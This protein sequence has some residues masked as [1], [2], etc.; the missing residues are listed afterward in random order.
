MDEDFKVGTS[1]AVIT[2]DKPL[3]M[4]GY[5]SRKEKAQGKLDDLYAKTLY[6]RGRHGLGFLVISL[7]L[8]R[9]DNELYDEIAKQIS[10]Q[11]GLRKEQIHVVATHTHSGPEISTVFWN[12]LP[13]SS[14]EEK[15][16]L[17]YRNQLIETV[18]RTAVESVEK[19]EKARLYVGK[20]L[21]E[22]VGSNRVDPS[23]PKDNEAMYLV[24][25]KDD[26]TYKVILVNYACHPTVLGPENK[27]YSGDLAGMTC[28]LIEDKFGVM[29]MY[30]NGAA[31]N[32]STRH[33][34][35]G[36]NYEWLKLLASRLAE[37]I[38]ESI[39]NSRYEP[40]EKNVIVSG[41]YVYRLKT[42][43]I[44]KDI[45]NILE[46]KKQIE[47]KLEQLKKRNPS[48]AEIRDLESRLE[49]I[50]VLLNRIMML[51]KLESIEARISYVKI[52]D[53]AVFIFFPGEVYVELQ[54]IAKKESR[55]PYVFFVGYADGYIGYVP[56]DKWGVEE[57]LMSYEKIVSIIDPGEVEKIVSIIREIVS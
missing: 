3:I 28:Q 17:D 37:P 52:G 39:S 12:T 16:I 10:Q 20:T 8:I 22:D 13:L 32:I 7:D 11:T 26:G 1:K 51:K 14:K 18:T 47:E 41:T 25:K 35:G 15:K 53:K 40:I 34:R 33:T 43:Y 24:A 36:Q 42:K 50:Q 21:I 46:M 23:G 44:E 19:A 2:P 56:F 5:I 48:H 9:I 38:I 57:S 55:Y 4:A 49:G 31:G 29:T 27:M 54:L 30:L 6:I 45:G